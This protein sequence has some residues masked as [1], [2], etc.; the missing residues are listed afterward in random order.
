M[1][2]AKIA[3]SSTQC[4]AQP[5]RHSSKKKDTTSK[6]AN[7]LRFGSAAV[8][9]RRGHDRAG[10]TE[11]GRVLFRP[12][13]STSSANCEFLH[14]LALC[15]SCGDGVTLSED[16]SHPVLVRVGVMVHIIGISRGATCVQS[17]PRCCIRKGCILRA[18]PLD[19]KSMG[20]R[21]HVQSLGRAVT[22]TD[23]NHDQKGRSL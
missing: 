16:L 12:P 3:R 17:C 9:Q 1:T 23:S 18:L 5:Y 22:Q 13:L 14:L 8:R 7:L 10:S 6:K 4:R 21:K 15:G 11:P 20:R 19:P 2:A